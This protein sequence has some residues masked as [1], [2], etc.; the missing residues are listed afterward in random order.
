MM[1]GFCLWETTWVPRSEAA[2]PSL[3]LRWR[4]LILPFRKSTRSD[5]VPEMEGRS[6]GGSLDRYLVRARFFFPSR[7]FRSPGS[8]LPFGSLSLY[9]TNHQMYISTSQTHGSHPLRLPHIPLCGP[10][11]SLRLMNPTRP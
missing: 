4:G 1:V 6:H 2:I 5:R 8:E 9:S 10:A 7:R 3:P 11:E